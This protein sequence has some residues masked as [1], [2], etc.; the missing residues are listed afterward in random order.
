VS[1]TLGGVSEEVRRRHEWLELLPAS[2]PFLT[3]PVVNR[4][5]PNFPAGVPQATKE[6]RAR[7]RTLVAEMMAGR[8]ASRHAVIHAMLHDV[9]GWGAHLVIGEMPASLTEI[10]AP[11]LRLLRR[12]GRRSRRRR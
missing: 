6:Q 11:R 5:M 4:V 7:V 2:G 9:L 1:R 10:V 12:A 3:L 8:G